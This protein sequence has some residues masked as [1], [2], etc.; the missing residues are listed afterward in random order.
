M[1]NTFL[2][3]SKEIANDFIQSIV[4]LDDKA[5]K[6][7]DEAKPDNDFD[8]LRITQSFAKEKK[9][10]AV[11]QPGSEVDI[12]NFKS[13]SNKADVVV[14]DWEINF[15]KE[16]KP[17]SEEEDD[18]DEPRGIYSKSVIKST[19]FEGDQPK[20]SLKMILV[21]TGDFTI[22][23]NII[24]EIHREVFNAKES[25]VLD[26]ENL[27]ITSSEFKVLVRAKKVEIN[28]DSNKEFE[29]FMLDY[30]EIPRFIL[31]EFTRMTSGLLSNFALLS[32]S[33][34]RQNSSKILGL[35]SKEMDSAYLGHKAIIPKQ[36]DAEDLLI[37]LFGDTVKDLLYYVNTNANIRENLIDSWIDNNIKEE[38]FVYEG[39]VFKRSKEVLK[40]ILNS[41][42]EDVKSRFNTILNTIDKALKNHLNQ[43]PTKIYTNNL[44][45]NESIEK[46]KCFAKLTHH[47]SLF[48]P[49]ET[50]PKLTLG[51]LIKSTKN[52]NYFICIQQ[53]CDSVR[54]PKDEERKF[55]FIP[56][57]ISQDKFDL[58]TPEGFGLKKDN[59]SYSIR[60]IKFVCADD[61]GLILAEKNADNKFI[62][63]QKFI[64]LEDEQ[65]EWILDLKD[66][67]SQRIIIDYT[68]RLS[69]VGLDESEWHRRF[70]S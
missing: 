58:L 27:C 12:E 16:V 67:H 32:L 34:L 40:K 39:K 69:R 22:L 11:Y 29:K 44:E 31:E 37:E 53:K 26:E 17:G 70:L 59:N 63:K 9:V 20:K 60:T 51:T 42:D 43:N 50:Q 55:L 52:D 24:Q 47:K 36:E 1:N 25:C 56:L 46:D 61:S 68:S 35:F 49:K 6:S 19:L 7:I 21:Y 8:S 62:F 65:Y 10:C 28:N 5:Y 3:K 18:H 48:I 45:I 41:K 57:T 38:D 30:E 2:D 64:E 33:T 14:L 23:R 13:I 54:I 4:F 66:L 15:P